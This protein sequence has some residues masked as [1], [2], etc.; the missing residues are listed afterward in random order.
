MQFTTAL[1]EFLL[2][3]AESLV[4]KGDKEV[5]MRKQKK[6]VENVKTL[7]TEHRDMVRK[8]LLFS[9]EFKQSLLIYLFPACY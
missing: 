2:Q 1:E 8:F 5:M 9:I 7:M 6:C 4:A 3:K